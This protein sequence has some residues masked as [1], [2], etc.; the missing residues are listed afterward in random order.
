MKRGISGFAFFLFLLPSLGAFEWPVEQR[1]LIATFGEYRWD[2]FLPGIDIGGGRQEVR[3]SE[4]GEIIYIHEEK[5]GLAFLPSGLGNYL[6]LEHERGLRTLYAHLEADSL[7]YENVQVEPQN[8]IGRVGSSGMSQGLY[9]HFQ[10]LDREMNQLVNPL[11]ILPPLRDMTR[12]VLEQVWLQKNRTRTPLAEQSTMASGTYNLLLSVYDP[13]GN[14]HYTRLMNP[15]KIQVFI[16]G[17]QLSSISFESL[18][19]EEGSMF[20][21]QSENVTSQLLY[22]S[23]GL[24]NM[25]T[26]QLTVGDSIVEI[27]VED[28]SRNRV[29]KDFRI[30]VTG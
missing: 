23:D 9:L 22:T 30:R 6:V 18:R 14:G 25:G 13:S 12:P 21:V 27:I 17:E 19:Y 16:N 2:D 3:P 8:I 15:H 1:I 7:L 10:V 24:L 26:F 4:K 5:S 11:L 28:F 29:T 20:L